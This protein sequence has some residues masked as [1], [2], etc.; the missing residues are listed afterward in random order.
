MAVAV[1]D[2]TDRT[3]DG[4]FAREDPVQV[5]IDVGIG[6]VK[7][8]DGLIRSVM[9][10]KLPGGR[11]LLIPSIVDY[12]GYMAAKTL[13][14]HHYWRSVLAE[15]VLKDASAAIAGVTSG[16]VMPSNPQKTIKQNYINS[17]VIEVLKHVTESANMEW[18]YDEDKVLNGT[19][20]SSMVMAYSNKI[21]TITDD[22]ASI[23]PSF[24]PIKA[25][26]KPSGYEFSDDW[27][28]AVRNVKVTNGA[29][30][31]FPVDPDAWV[32]DESWDSI[33]G[34]NIPK[35]IYSLYTPTRNS[36]S[37]V[38]SYLAKLVTGPQI[39]DMNI[40]AREF[41]TVNVDDIVT[42]QLRLVNAYGSSTYGTDVSDANLALPVG[43]W[44]EF[45]FWMKP[46]LI[47]GTPT[48]VRL[49]LVDATTGGGYSRDIWPDVRATNQ[50]TF[51]CY[52]LPTSTSLNGWTLVGTV[53]NIDYIY[54][55]F[56]KTGGIG[57]SIPVNCKGW[58]VGSKVA[59][60]RPRFYRLKAQT[61]TSAGT[62]ATWRI[63]VDQSLLNDA[64]MLSRA[65]SELLRL[66]LTA[67]AGKAVINGNTLFRRPGY[68]LN[69]DFTGTLAK[70]ST[71]R[72]SKITHVV[73][74]GKYFTYLDWDNAWWN[75]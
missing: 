34:V 35:S 40:P 60:A 38:V 68:I 51:F 53:N 16:K 29:E 7:M 52:T 72:L 55:N 36:S 1:L 5:Y 13:Y 41:T 48:A 11:V 30:E 19:M 24:Y 67:N 3:L 61:A 9:T 64:M 12:G 27:T 57:D 58:T 70:S 25:K 66:N 14:E 63:I 28:Y 69:V 17:Y 47:G 39:R 42:M 75:A 56:F 62:P 44:D 65:Q 10:K 37:G 74:G 50:W 4:I 73:Q 33:I 2:N 26:L 49:A 22:P 71:V 32:K 43:G 31:V 18:F 15:Q 54:W 45:W 8:L 20:I 6:R 59:L 21:I 46:N 23:G